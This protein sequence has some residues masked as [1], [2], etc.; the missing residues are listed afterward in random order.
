MLCRYHRE[1]CT[2]EVRLGDA[3]HLVENREHL[4]L[5]CLL[6]FRIGDRCRAEEHIQLLTLDPVCEGTLHLLLR[7]VRQKVGYDEDRIPRL[8]A[9]IEVDGATVTQHHTSVQCE[10]GHRPLILLDATI[11]VR[12]EERE[13]L[14]LIERIRLQ[15]EA[16][17]VNVGDIEMHTLIE[18]TLTDRGQDDALATVI[19]IYLVAGLI[20]LRT[21]E[22]LVAI[23]LCD[24][25][26]LTYGLTLD[27]RMIEKRLVALAERHGLLHILRTLHADVLNLIAELLL[28]LLSFCLR[29]NISS[30]KA[31][32]IPLPVITSCRTPSHPYAIAG[33][34]TPKPR[35]LMTASPFYRLSV[36]FL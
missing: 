34:S 4:Q 17:A 15:V 7:E 5:E 33:F 25:D 35:L 29:H 28:E 2:H 31:A 12:L 3:V 9:E 20:L 21:L 8:L 26:R 27:L 23:L 18:R 1:L 11:V 6:H 24:P 14:L 16:R 32:L 30:F 13:L 10:R 22:W 19:E 36:L